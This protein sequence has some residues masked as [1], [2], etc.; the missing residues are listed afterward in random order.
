MLDNLNW[1]D[2]ACLAVIGLG[3]L[4]GL[5]RGFTREIIGLFGWVIA[6][7]LAN[8]WYHDLIPRITPYISSEPMAGVIAF[9][10]ILLLV[11]VIINVFANA[12]VGANSSRFALL[13]R[14]DKLLGLGCGGIKGYAGLSIIYLLGGIIFPSAEWP[15]SLQKSQI[16]PYVYDGANYINNLLP[17]SMQRNVVVPQTT[18]PRIIIPNSAKT[19]NDA[20]QPPDNSV[21]MDDDGTNASPAQ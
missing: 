20:T 15:N 18:A 11:I 1:V 12:I 14:L 9:I 8:R 10:G 17:N 2:L 19:P 6:A 13:G 7:S 3:A 4:S 5:S 16:I 21:P